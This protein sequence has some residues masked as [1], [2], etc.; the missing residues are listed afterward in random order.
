MKFH[1]EV[2]RQFLAEKKF[3]LKKSTWRRFSHPKDLMKTFFFLFKLHTLVNQV[4]NDPFGTCKQNPRRN[5]EGEV[6][7]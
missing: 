3:G 2:P 4:K 6:R 7:C 5:F 1:S